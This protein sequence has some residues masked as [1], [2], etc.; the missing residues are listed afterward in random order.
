[1]ILMYI[2]GFARSLSLFMT[3]TKRY[4]QLKCR[5]LGFLGILSAP[6]LSENLISGYFGL[7][8]R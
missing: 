4:N 1:M 2:K 8:M 3:I 7:Y 5:K 6:A